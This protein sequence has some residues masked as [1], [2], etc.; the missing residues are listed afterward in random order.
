MKRF[1]PWV[2][3]LLLLAAAAQEVLA[4]WRCRGGGRHVVR[5]VVAWVLGR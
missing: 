1:V 4:G 5:N 2:L 3:A